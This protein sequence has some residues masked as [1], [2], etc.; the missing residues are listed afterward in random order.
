[1]QQTPPQS[2]FSDEQQKDT[3][4]GAV[5]DYL[6][7]GTMPQDNADT[8]RLITRSS[9]LTLVNRVLYHVGHKGTIPNRQAVVPTHLRAELL[10]QSHG[11][12]IAG[13]F[14]GPR[15]YQC[16]SRSWW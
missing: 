8:R 12:L 5:I 16:L 14:S 1:M 6:T 9:E 2:D 4:L 10:R 3:I 13:H 11:G 15:L 7:S